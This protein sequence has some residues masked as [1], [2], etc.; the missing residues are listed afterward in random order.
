[1][2][3]VIVYHSDYGAT[4]RVARSVAAGI[5]GAG[6]GKVQ[7]ELLRA[8]ES[9]LAA[10]ETAD[11]CVFGAPVHMGSVAW[12]MKR[13]LDA[14]ARFWREGTLEGRLGAAFVTFGGF[15][16]AGG[17]AELALLSI[18]A[19]MAELGMLLIPCPKSLPGYA[20]AGLHWGLAVRTGREDGMP[21]GVGERELAAARAFG[22]HIAEVMHR[23]QR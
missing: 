9:A 22:A 2:R 23:L 17:G 4:E 5:E 20:D 13:F 6:L 11:A 3:A 19:T 7:A 21:R 14:T 10:L 1:M 12:P 18:W 15:G 16:G 8:D